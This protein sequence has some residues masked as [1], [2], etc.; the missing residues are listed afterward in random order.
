MSTCQ[1]QS[2][3]VRGWDRPQQGALLLL[4]CVARTERGMARVG[5]DCN[6][7]PSLVLLLSLL[8]LLLLVL[9]VVLVLLLLLLMH[10]VLTRQRCQQV[11]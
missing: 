10:V 11:C 8:L 3:L 9:V 4:I 1:L 5:C 7:A 6:H 2:A